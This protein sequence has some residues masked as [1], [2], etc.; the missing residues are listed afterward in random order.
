MCRLVLMNKQGEK[1]IN[2]RYGLGNYLKF[3]EDRFGGHGNGVIAV[4]NKKIVLYSKGVKLDVRDIAKQLKSLQYDWAIFHT[5]FASVG[6]KSDRNCHPFVKGRYIIAMNGTEEAVSF[7]SDAKDITDTEAIL[8]IMDKYN[9]GIAALTNLK[10]IF[11]GFQKGEPFMVANNIRNVRLLYNKENKA[12]IFASEFPKTLKKD[13]YELKTRYIW[14]NNEINE[15]IIKKNKPSK[16]VKTSNWYKYFDFD[17]VYGQGYFK[18]INGE[19][20]KYAL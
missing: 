17:E 20:D 19:G 7:L 6:S 14:N 11:V 18:S 5:R 2:K 4:K 10:S 8:D 1:E 13:I 15:N 16:P 12:I 3:L 9:L